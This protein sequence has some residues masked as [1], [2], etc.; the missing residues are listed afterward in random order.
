MRKFKFPSIIF[1]FL[2]IFIASLFLTT[3]VMA[4]CDPSIGA[5][6]LGDCLTL[7]DGS[8]VAETY[9]KPTVLVNL[10]VRNIF[11]VAG[12]ILLLMT[13]YAGFQVLTGGSK[14][15]EKAKEVAGNALLGFVI[16]FAAFWILRIISITTGADILF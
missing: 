9:N 5:I 16:M 14:G 12:F 10:V 1:S 6:E 4:I 13:I 15:L 8:T 11:I 7:S 2:A 3:P